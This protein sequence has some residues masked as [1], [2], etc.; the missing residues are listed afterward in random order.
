[1]GDL[2]RA[3]SMRILMTGATSGIGLD[4]ARRL[5]AEGHELIVLCRDP[6]RA[7]QRLGEATDK[8]QLLQTDLADLTEVHES[9]RRLLRLNQ[10]LDAMVL[11]A[12]LQYAGD[13]TPRFSAQGIELTFAVNHLSHQHIVNQLLPLMT[14]S[15]NG[16]IV[17]TASEVHNPSSGG[18]RVGKPASLGSL[19]GLNNGRGFVMVDGSTSFDA[20]KAYKDSKLCNLLLAR[21]LVAKLN[22]NQTAIPVIT[23]SP[24]LVIPHSS[25]GFFRYSRQINPLGQLLFAFVA[26]DL[27][28]LTVSV[29]SAGELL[30]GLISRDD[31]GPGFHYLNN[32]LKGP[33]QHQ[34]LDTQT[35]L[36]ASDQ[37]LAKDLFERSDE[38]IRMALKEPNTEI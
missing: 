4:A 1:M 30:V 18:G 27:L 22:Q 21:Q 33:G 35:S 19:H 2:M 15:N 7:T 25:D 38:L 24:G 28:R 26:R 34:F 8:L 16:R 5:L 29:E 32:T 14:L 12:G 11:N 9:C 23:W 17:I 37:S 36:E 3:T 20:D 31:L 10:E 6:E 13:K